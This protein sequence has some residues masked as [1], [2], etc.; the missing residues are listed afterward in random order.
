MKRQDVVNFCRDQL[1]ADLLWMIN[2]PS[3][4]GKPPVG[5]ESMRIETAGGSSVDASDVDADHLLHWFTHQD[6]QQPVC[7][8]VGRYF[9]RLV[10][11]WLVFLRRVELIARGKA[12]M[13]GGRTIGEIDFLYH[14]ELGQLIHLEV[15][16]KFYLGIYSTKSNRLQFVGPNLNDTYERKMDRLFQ[17]Q[18]QLESEIFPGRPRRVALVKGTL[19]YPE[20]C[21]QSGDVASPSTA[22]PTHCRGDWVRA[23]AL[24]RWCDRN[25]GSN[26]QLTLP[27]KPFWLSGFQRPEQES[28]SDHESMVAA[29]L[30]DVKTQRRPVMALVT[31]AAEMNIADR[32]DFKR[33]FVVPD[34]WPDS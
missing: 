10:W 19:F 12:I 27:D 29:C 11:Y 16:V 30:Q 24:L 17:H 31:S 20:Y 14:D 23:S 2:S 33:L 15:A 25:L 1:L 8:R 4:L 22:S 32:V 34:P 28:Q 21:T 13:K 18:L 26:E 9:E 3:L 5:C 7:R 6:S